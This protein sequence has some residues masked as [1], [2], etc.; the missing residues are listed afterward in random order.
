MEL[1]LVV[2]LELPLE[3]GLEGG[4]G[5]QARHLVLVLVGE[6]LGVV[7]RDRFGQLASGPASLLLG[8]RTCSTSAW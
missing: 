7:A 2:A 4:V 1:Q 5:V 6:Q 3:P 8:C